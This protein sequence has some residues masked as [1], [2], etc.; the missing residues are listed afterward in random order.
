MN[1]NTLII[2]LSLMFIFTSGQS[3]A[4]C[5]KEQIAKWGSLINVCVNEK[6]LYPKLARYREWEGDGVLLLFVKP[7]GS[8]VNKKIIEST[9]YEALDNEMIATISRAKFPELEYEKDDISP[10][11][12]ILPFRFRLAVPAGPSKLDTNSNP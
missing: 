8:V 2:S 7:E 12:I 9:G 10:K 5:S 6:I 4:E 1:K 3:F 11:S